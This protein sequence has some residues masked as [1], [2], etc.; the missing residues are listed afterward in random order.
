VGRVREGEEERPI[1][2]PFPNGKGAGCVMV[3]MGFQV[4]VWFEEGLSFSHL[5]ETG[6]GFV[7]KAGKMSKPCPSKTSSQVRKSPKKNSYAPKN[8]AAR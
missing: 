3:V 7:L 8:C 2:P 1:P 5:G 4:N 6:E